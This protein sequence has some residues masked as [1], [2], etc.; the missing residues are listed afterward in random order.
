MKWY[1]FMS[2]LSQNHSPRGVPLGHTVLSGMALCNYLLLSR[3]AATTASTPPLT[4]FCFL[5]LTIDNFNSFSLKLYEK[6]RYLYGITCT[7]IHYIWKPQEKAHKISKQTFVVRLDTPLETKNI[8]GQQHVFFFKFHC[9]G[10]TNNKK[11]MFFLVKHTHVP[12]LLNN[13]TILESSNLV[14]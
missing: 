8:W 1:L 10:F 9:P 7:Y 12:I 5:S 2:L 4:L 13:K 6:V 11:L 3:Q 14:K